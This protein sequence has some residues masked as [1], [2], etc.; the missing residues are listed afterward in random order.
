MAVPDDIIFVEKIE[1]LE[2][3]DALRTAY[4]A[5]YASDPHRN[6]FVSWP[7]LR[8]YFESMAGTWC[9]LAARSMREHRYVG[10]CPL[11][12]RRVA[13]GRLALDTELFFAINPTADYT[14]IIMAQ[15]LEQAACEAVTNAF[16]SAIDAMP[17]D[18]F[19]VN[20]VIDPRVDQIVEHLCLRNDLEKQPTNPCRSIKLPPTWDLYL[21]E[22]QGYGARRRLRY[23]IR[24]LE[25]LPGFR[26]KEA[27]AENLDIC[28]DALLLLN[29]RRWQTNRLKAQKTYGELFRAAFARGVC[30]IFVAWSGEIPIAAQAAFTGS[31]RRS[32]GVY[33]LGYNADY[34]R[35]SPGTGIIALTIQLAIEEN[36]GEYDFLRGDEPYK[37][38]F[39]AELRYL[40]NWLVRRRGNRNRIVKTGRSFYYRLKA[41]ARKVLLGK[42]LSTS[43]YVA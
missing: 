3:F 27:T 18:N 39:G 35:Y 29:H 17:W 37:E 22:Q 23:T 14:G 30:R 16:A 15:N 7:W 42:P 13:I 6:A 24:T 11:E 2:A 9:V 26:L 12:I 33:M 4:E 32:W 21:G 8:A 31:E 28:I 20:N 1:T 25:R 38:R 43:A 10:F 41:L 36:Y 19:H 34:S 40:E 5:I